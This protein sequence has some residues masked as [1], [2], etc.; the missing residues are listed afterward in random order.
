MKYKSQV[1]T[2]ASGSIGGI[3]YSHNRGGMYTRARSIPVNPSSTFQQAMR[4]YLSNLVVR[5]GQTLTQLQRD[6]WDV[7]A[8]NVLRTD[9]LG[10]PRQLT[11]LNWYLAIN[12]FRNQCFAG[13]ATIDDAPTVMTEGVLTP[14]TVVSA[15]AATEVLSIGFTNTDL[16][17]SAISGCLGVYVSP[18]QSAGINFYK[19]PYRF[20]GRISGAPTPPVSPMPVTSPFPFAV[21]N[22]LFVQFRS[23]N[24]TTDGRISPSFRNFATGI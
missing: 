22:K 8:G 19:G 13:A 6:A 16:W 9:A 14:P 1:Y 12:S 18:P 5:W 10:E 17:A 20:A 11:G 7:Y 24:P 4:G 23:T 15:T 3:T 2:Q 21:G